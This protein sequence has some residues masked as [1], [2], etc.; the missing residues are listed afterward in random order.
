MCIALP[1]RV[2]EILPERRAVVSFDGVESR[3][4]LRLLEDCRVGDYVLIHAGYAIERISQAD[5]AE[6]ERILKELKA[7]LGE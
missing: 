5:A 6:N 4:S 2:L 1:M 3:I 7:G